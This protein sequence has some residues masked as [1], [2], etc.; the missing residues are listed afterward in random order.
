MKLIEIA[1]TVSLLGIVAAA[2]GT[3]VHS[4][5]RML[6]D[7]S[8]RAATG[9][10]LRTA[11]GV[12]AA[13]LSAITTTDVRAVARDSLALRVMRGSAVVSRH[14]NDQWTLSYSGLRDP[15]DQKDSLLV[16]GTERAGTFRLISADPL[17]IQ[18][19]TPLDIGSVLLFFESGG[20]HLS[21]N[22][23]RYRRGVEGR[24]P[25]TDE[26][27]DHR[28]SRFHLEAGGRVLLL[29]LRER[30]ARNQTQLV[31]STGIRLAE[32]AR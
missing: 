5:S 14:H 15:D 26:L 7:I 9:E 24:Q 2:S 23:L 20:Y 6:R 12:I 28:G 27:I 8:D 31:K 18:T 25:L 1:T 16:V 10:A 3:L 32:P 19:E 17:M 30:R 21:T 29:Q 4:Q 13:E 22:A 11:S